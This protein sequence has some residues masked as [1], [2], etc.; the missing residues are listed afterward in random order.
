[1]SDH[2]QPVSPSTAWSPFRQTK[3][4][5]IWTTTVIDNIGSWMYGAAA[6][7]LMTELT[8]D[9][10]MVS[11]V[12]V[13]SSLPIFLFALPA[14]ALTDIVDKRRLLIVVESAISVLSILFAALVWLDR[15]TPATLLVFMFL[16]QVCSALEAPAWQAIVPRL[17]PKTDLSA[18]V[19]ANSLGVNVSRAIGPALG[20]VLTVGLGIS[21]PFWVNGFSNF[22]SIGA[23]LWW[24]SPKEGD[25][26][27]PEERFT[28][29]IRAGI[30]YVRHNSALRA[31]LFR[32]VAFFLCASAYWALLPLVARTQI[33]GGPALYGVLQGAIG[34]GAIGCALSL[35]WLKAKLGPDRLVAVA[36][37]G[38]AIALVLFGAAR[39]PWS[40]IVASFL[41][42]ASWI[43]AVSNLN[44]SAQFALP[45]WVRGRGLSIYVTA[46]FGAMTFGSA[47]W[48][49]LA[50]MAGLPMAHFIAAA[51][52]LI[53]IPLTRN[54]KL[55]TAAGI[56]LAP[57]MHWPAPVVSLEIEHDEG[58]VLVTVEYHVGPGERE[59]FLT[60]LEHLASGRRRDGAYT[61]GVF[62]DI[63]ER[64]RFLETFMVESWLE[65]LRQHRR[66]TNADRVF[67]EHVHRLL[68]S[69]PKVTHLIAASARRN[70]S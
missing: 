51:C 18:A 38:T 56:D 11:L 49:Q 61:W 62:E 40:A 26:R 70:S 36:T 13:A 64:G 14:G 15:I 42:G 23:L 52:A 31:T 45:E 2:A 10:L 16:I 28:S 9:P 55:Q 4:A 6:A 7:W 21:A 44:V 24:R 60:A 58:P 68:R 41:A 53:G 65:H 69:T 32:A 46:F 30:R 25:G 1:M 54:W 19:A 67:Q 12:Q 63:A 50:R 34:V 27:L 35:Q 17:V 43:A 22:G 8:V 57:S 59:A 20:G 39:E 3:F 29:A 47:L 33:C 48:G 66:V 5:V 37:I